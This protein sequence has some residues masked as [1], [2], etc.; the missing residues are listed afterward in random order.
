MLYK[1]FAASILACLL[2]SAGLV[3]AQDPELFPDT[4]GR[5][6]KEPKLNQCV[7]EKLRSY[8]RKIPISLKFPCT[9]SLSVIAWFHQL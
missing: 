5:K 1:L 3:H 9:G 4:C 2:L 8:W 6:G 7:P